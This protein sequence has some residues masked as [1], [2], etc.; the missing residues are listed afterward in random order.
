[1][2]SEIDKSPIDTSVFRKKRDIDARDI[3]PLKTPFF[4]E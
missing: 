2:I 4:F 1:M 3:P